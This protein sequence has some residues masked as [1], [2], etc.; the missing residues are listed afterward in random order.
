MLLLGIFGQIVVTVPAI[1][2]TG[3]VE[4]LIASNVDTATLRIV[5]QL[6]TLLLSLIYVPLQLTCVILL[7]FDVR[8]RTEGLDL[9]LETIDPEAENAAKEVQM[10]LES[11][12]APH[13]GGWPTWRE[14]GYFALFSVAAGVV[15]GVIYAVFF[16]I[17]LAIFTSGFGSF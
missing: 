3:L 13:A 6:I 7:Y 12:P 10:T 1:L 11:S 5:Q 4:A 9:A 16:A 17:A 15:C 14:F 8:V 2:F